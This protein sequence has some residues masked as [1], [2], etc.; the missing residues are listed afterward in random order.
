MKKALLF[1]LVTF[2]FC[3]LGF[4]QDFSLD[5]LLKMRTLPY[6]EFETYVH[7][8]GYTL[9]HLE[10][11]DRCTV[12]RD[13]DNVVSYC[14]YYDDGYSYHNHVSVKFETPDKAVY[15]K[16]KHQV[17][18]TM[19]YHKTR[20]RRFSNEH[21]LEHIYVNDAVSVH[22]Y[23]IAFRDDPKPYYEIEVHSIYTAW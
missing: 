3:T 15:E 5:E 6:P 17:E 12:F 14:H 16:I 20:L 2:S 23:D 10:Y 8:K 13:G 21:Y 18:A 19:T 22:M 11:N 9:N 7:D 4:S 1:V